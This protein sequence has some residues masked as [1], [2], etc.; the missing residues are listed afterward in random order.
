MVYNLLL[1]IIL[2]AINGIFSASELAFLKI[3][4]YELK[5]KIKIHDKKAIQIN[6]ILSDQSAF[7]STIQISITLAGFLASAFAADYFADYFLQII[8]ILMCVIFR[9]TTVFSTHYS[10]HIKYTRSQLRIRQVFTALYSVLS[11]ML[12][13]FSTSV[14]ITTAQSRPYRIFR[15]FKALRYISAYSSWFTRVV[16]SH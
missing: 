14:I 1:L 5:N 10:R 11:N 4:K 6:K 7:L 12:C 9:A 3:N 8:N 13:S 15:L 2:I 16:T